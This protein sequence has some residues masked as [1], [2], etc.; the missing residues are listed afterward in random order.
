MCA[1]MLKHNPPPQRGFF[2]WFNRQVDAITRGFGHAVEW[3]IARTVTAL[4]LLLVFLYGIWHLFH[5][6]PTSFV[7][8]EDQGYAMAAIIMPQAASLDRTQAIAEQVDAI[9]AKIP[10]IDTRTMV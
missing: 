2:A 8:N 5:I 3:V 10:G 4:V 7:P 9:F 6:L 1:L